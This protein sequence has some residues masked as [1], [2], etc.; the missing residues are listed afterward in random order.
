MTTR[1]RLMTAFT[2]AVALAVPALAQNAGTANKIE[3]KIRAA[4]RY[5]LAANIP[6]VQ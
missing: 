2:I 5:E 4:I 6:L 3:S 1:I